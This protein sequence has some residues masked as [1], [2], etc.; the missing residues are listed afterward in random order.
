[1]LGNL[2]CPLI[3][4]KD[5]V[6]TQA[7]IFSAAIHLAEA[8]Q[9]QPAAHIINLCENRQDFITVL[10]GAALSGKIS[11]LP[12]DSARATLDKIRLALKSSHCIHD[13]PETIYADPLSQQVITKRF[14]PLSISQ[15]LLYLYTSGST[16]EPKP[17]RKTLQHLLDAAE[18]AI[19]RLSLDASCSLI[20][21]VPSQHMYGLESSVF[22][23]LSANAPVWHRKT[24]FIDDILASLDILANQRPYL[25]STPLHLEKMLAQATH[26]VDSPPAAIISATAPLSMELAQ[27]L[28][29]HFNTQVIEVYG[30]TETS[31]IAT[32]H[33]ATAST[34]RPYGGIDFRANPQQ[35]YLPYANQWLALHDDIEWLPDGCFKLLGRRQDV[36]K[37][38]GKRHSLVYLNQLLNQIPEITEGVIL[39]AE[40]DQRLSAFVVS[41]HSQVKRLIQGVFL[42]AVDPLFIP[43]PIIRLD[44]LPR[45]GTG[46][47]QMGLLRRKLNA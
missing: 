16:G 42:D 40:P 14:D 31:S 8:L 29:Q 23:P 7:D 18:L 41:T 1:M 24:F 37:V 32:R 21:T 10:L 9:H 27:R 46:K 25:V 39:Q 6:L 11:V 35:V 34:W 33:A 17:V 45:T 26:A 44:A 30:S 47:V 22:W 12:P 19:T 4:F 2:H 28:E 13:L 15:S 38:G 20:S 5:R 36:V 3:Y 43:R